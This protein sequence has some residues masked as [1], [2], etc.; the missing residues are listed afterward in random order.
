MFSA[1]T[2]LGGPS[3]TGDNIA[4]SDGDTGLFDNAF[5]GEDPV[6]QI[7]IILLCVRV[8]LDGVLG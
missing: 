2:L 6:R 1:L 5:V 7:N 3:D 4:C 8:T